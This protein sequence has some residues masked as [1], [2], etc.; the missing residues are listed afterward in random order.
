MVAV[1]E[2]HLFLR[3]SVSMHVPSLRA[4]IINPPLYRSK[5]S[6]RM[7]GEFEGG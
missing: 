3:V 6:A 2:S 1:L 5:V 4:T 7:G